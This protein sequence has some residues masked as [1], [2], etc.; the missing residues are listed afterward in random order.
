MGRRTWST[1]SSDPVLV[2][3]DGWASCCGEE[4]AMRPSLKVHG[5]EFLAWMCTLCVG[6][7]LM[8]IYRSCTGEILFIRKLHQDVLKL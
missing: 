1:K 4:D 2:A 5:C 7:E 8:I 3:S 6:E